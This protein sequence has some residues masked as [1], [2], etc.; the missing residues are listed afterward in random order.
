MTW[1]GSADRS[2]EWHPTD[3]IITSSNIDIIT[4]FVDETKLNDDIYEPID[5]LPFISYLKV[6]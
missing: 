5:H 1:S 2:G 6:N 4:S 3:N